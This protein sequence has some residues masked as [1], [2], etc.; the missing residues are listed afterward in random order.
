MGPNSD[1]VDLT[2]QGSACGT[3]KEAD[4]SNPPF[5]ADQV[6]SAL[7]LDNLGLRRFRTHSREHAP[8]R[9]GPA[10]AHHAG[11]R[12]VRHAQP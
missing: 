2:G 8:N 7:H 5:C 1:F 11:R 6:L 10:P 3:L 12:L 9:S 4:R